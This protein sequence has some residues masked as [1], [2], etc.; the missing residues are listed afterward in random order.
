MANVGDREFALAK[1][2]AAA[3]FKVGQSS[4]QADLL[5]EE[6]R[7]FADLVKRDHD[8]QTFLD[9]PAVDTEA[10]KRTIE[11]LFRGKFSDVLVDALQ[12]LNRNERLGIIGGIAAATHQL[13]EESQ[14]RV[15]LHVHSAA[16]LSDPI[17]ARLRERIGQATGKQVDLLERVDSTLI[18][19][20]VVQLGDRKFDGSVRRKLRKIADVLLERSSKELH[21]GRTYT[22]GAA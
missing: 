18:G 22:A 21:M 3:I 2:Y 9:S 4:E 5:A 12:V 10:R 11:K 20:V 13:H 7:A 6:V 1:V 15:E 17:R 14:G 16:P 19:G 8:F